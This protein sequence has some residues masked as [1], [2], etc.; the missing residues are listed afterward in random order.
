MQKL[1]SVLRTVAASF[2]LCACS[3]TLEARDA[4]PAPTEAG[5]TPCAIQCDQIGAL[6]DT[7]CT[8]ESDSGAQI[9]S[10]QGSCAMAV[11]S[12]CLPLCPGFTFPVICVP[13][14]DCAD[15]GTPGW[16]GI[17]EKN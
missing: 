11:L 13:G 16:Y 1:S 17:G 12:Q 5:P 14:H 15:A 8:Q 9:A 6:C 4:G 10:C 7:L 3:G 2:L